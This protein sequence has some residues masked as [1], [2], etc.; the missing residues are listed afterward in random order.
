[1][2][3]R[4]HRESS[5]PAAP[6]VITHA[7]PEAQSVA[8]GIFVDVGS[9]DEPPALHGASHALEHMLFKG[10]RS[11]DVHALSA[12]LDALG[13][14]ANAWTSRERTCF[15]IQVL[16]EHW[17][18]AL[19]LL[20][21]MI[22]APALPEDEWRRERDVIEAEMAMAED[23]PED[24]A[25]DQHMAALFPN[26]ALGR[27][28]LGTRDSLAGIAAGDL[29]AYLQRHYVAQ[30]MLVAAAGAIE[31][32][33]L[34]EAVRHI[35]WRQGEFLGARAPVRMHGGL[36]RVAREG[37]QAQLLVSYP[38]VAAAD[39]ARPLAWLGNQVLGGGMSSHLFRELREKRGLAYSIGSH[40]GTF[41]TQGLWTISCGC[42][43]AQAIEAARVL[44][45]TLA[46]F[47]DAITEEE[48]A[49]AK[50]Q[51]VIQLRM[52]MDSVEGQMMYLGARLDEPEL[53]S[54]LDWVARIERVSLDALRGWLRDRL[55][56]PPL[57][58]IVA[59]PSELDRVCASIAPCL[60]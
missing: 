13:G 30:R 29:R 25:M 58:T 20:A 32:R 17:R 8:L 56:R 27:N 35:A 46:R 47:V 50:R 18:E 23:N 57:W 33:A 52:A 26:D 21:E 28:V 37:E 51:L 43:P 10:T 45:A 59:P 48:L 39:D 5:P 54:P 42:A 60:N 44:S 31:H 55:A 15:H 16:R 1:M 12:R 38:G 53:H 41:T 9:R 24:W 49:R 14:Q 4:Y 6:R 22:C 36:H 34:L 11:L 40:L 3:A 2:S 19:D 7:M